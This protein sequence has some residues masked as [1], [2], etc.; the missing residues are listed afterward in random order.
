MGRDKALIELDG[1]PLVVRAARELAEVFSDVVIASPLRQGYSDFGIELVEDRYR[2]CGPLAGLHAALVRARKRPV[3]VLAC[4]YPL[5]DSSLI[6]YL[7]VTE[8]Q[9]AEGNLSHDSRVSGAGAAWAKVPSWQDRLHPLCGLYSAECREAIEE[10]LAGDN[11]SVH[12]FLDRVETQIFDVT[13]E[14]PFWTPGIL[15]NVNGPED[16]V[17]LTTIQESRARSLRAGEDP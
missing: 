4:D 15:I 1:E 12:G 17:G 7:V 3:F 16:L 6:S 9:S 8:R 2:N 11:R 13:E 5:V 10:Y 14:L